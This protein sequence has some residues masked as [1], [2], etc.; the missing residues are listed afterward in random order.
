M[1]LSENC[2]GSNNNII[3]CFINVKHLV[4]D[5]ICFFRISKQHLRETTKVKYFIS[6]K[7]E[8][9]PYS[10]ETGK[11]CGVTRFREKDLFKF[12]CKSDLTV[13]RIRMTPLSARSCPELFCGGFRIKLYNQL[14][15]NTEKFATYGDSGSLVFCKGMSGHFECIGMVEGGVSYKTCVLTPIQSILATLKVSSLKNFETK[16]RFD[17]IEHKLDSISSMLE[18]LVRK[19]N[20]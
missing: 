9:V 7:T 19:S 1:V 4:Y 17:A 13:G 2:Y 14:E 5:G 16:S 11:T 3:H 10:F 12:G 15:V 18:E 8:K 6:G 20:E